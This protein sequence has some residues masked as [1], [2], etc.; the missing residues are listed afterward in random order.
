M[1]RAGELPSA[2]ETSPSKW[3]RQT[4]AG[5]AEDQEL[6]TDTIYKGTVIQEYLQFAWG[7]LS[8]EEKR[9]ARSVVMPSTSSLATSCSGSG[10]AELVHDLLF[11]SFGGAPEL[12]S[13]CEMVGFKRQHLMQ[14]VHTALKAE[15]ACC[16]KE[17]GDL[18]SGVAACSVHE[19]LC[20]VESYTYMAIVGY[21]CKDM[22]NLKS[23]PKQM[24]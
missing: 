22:P 10:M 19:K 8:E 13:P 9:R 16:L 23:G 5:A 4:Q 1:K 6:D 21:S 17:L 3:A 15:N 18:S 7:K 11:R 20:N 2:K 14:T 12:K 24:F